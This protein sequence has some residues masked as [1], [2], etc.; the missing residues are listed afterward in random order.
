MAGW[1]AHGG[2]N[3]SDA[4]FLCNAL[5]VAPVS[6]LGSILWPRTTW[7]TWTALALVG[8]CAVEI[9]QGALL[10]ERTASYVDV[11]ANTLGGLLGALVVLAWRRVS[12]RRTAAGT[13]PSSPVGPRRP[14]DPRS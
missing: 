1:L 9:T 2:L 13:P 6:A 4:E 11:V 8:A 10:T 12:R 5:I 14:R 7:R 3:Q